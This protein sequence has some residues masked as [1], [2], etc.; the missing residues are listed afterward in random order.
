M[1][2]YSYLAFLALDEYY[3]VSLKYWTNKFV[4]YQLSNQPCLQF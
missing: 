1:A 4:S 2:L 3:F